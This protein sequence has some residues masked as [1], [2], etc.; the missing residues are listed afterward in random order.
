MQESFDRD[1]IRH[2]GDRICLGLYEKGIIG[3]RYVSLE[4][5]AKR[6]GYYCF[7]KKYSGKSFKSEIKCLAKAGKVHNDGKSAWKVVA[8]SSFGIRYIIQKISE[9]QEGSFT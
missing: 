5:A 4:E 7:Q 3:Y 6:I 8:L 1:N 2:I 9:W